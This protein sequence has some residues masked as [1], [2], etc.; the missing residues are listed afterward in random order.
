MESS[1]SNKIINNEVERTSVVDPQ[2]TP[3]NVNEFKSPS[4]FSAL[5]DVDEAEIESTSL[6][7]LTR[8]GRESKPPIK[9]QDLEWTTIQGRGKHGRRGRGPKH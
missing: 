8:G 1:P 9:F 7:G 4:C 3:S 2:T 5:G 6:L